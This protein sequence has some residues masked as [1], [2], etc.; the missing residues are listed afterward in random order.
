MSLHLMNE[1]GQQRKRYADELDKQHTRLQAGETSDLF[2]A[3]FK[4]MAVGLKL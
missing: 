4:S 2:S 3:D 1:P